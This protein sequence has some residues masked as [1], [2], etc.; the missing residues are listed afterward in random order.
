MRALVVEDNLEI[1]ECMEECLRD[2][3]IAADCFYEGRNSMEAFRLVDYDIFILDLNLPDADGLDI[4][5]AIRD[6]GVNTPVLIVSARARIDER[7][8]G[9]DLGADDYLVKPFGLREL[10]ARW[11]GGSRRTLRIVAETQ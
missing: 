11:P 2:M 3:D 5:K 9:L 8:H 10:V 1:S 4:L 7:V 6:K